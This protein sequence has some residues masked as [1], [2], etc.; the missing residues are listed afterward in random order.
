M[1]GDGGHGDERVLRAAGRGADRAAIRDGARG[2]S[3]A[4]RFAVLLLFVT[5]W[6]TLTAYWAGVRIISQ[7]ERY[8]IDMEMALF[9]A[10]AGFV[11]GM[12][13]WKKHPELRRWALVAVVVACSVQ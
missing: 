8:H 9:V 4:R 3:F 1:A 6:T 7:A 5:G 13:L 12:A 2:G 10:A 11:P